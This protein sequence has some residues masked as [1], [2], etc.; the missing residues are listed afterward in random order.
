MT[1]FKEILESI[2]G[3][4]VLD[5]ATGA[6]RF[7]EILKDHLASYA[8]IIG[9]DNSE[10]AKDG[11]LRAFDDP[12]IRFLA[13]DAHTLDF[14]DASFDTVG[15]CFSLH[16]LPDPLPVLHEMKRVLQPGGHLIV[17][18]MY[19]DNQSETQMT[20]VLLHDWWGAID[21][22]LGICHNATY[23]RQ[24]IF[25]MLQSLR[26]GNLTVYDLVDLTDDPHEQET[27]EFIDNII[28]QYIRERIPGVP[29]ESTLK[30]QGEALRQRLREIGY[31][32]ASILVSVM[33][34]H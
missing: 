10:R 17:S 21:T 32:N 25:A 15:I 18:E 29:N 14:P 9:V 11:F 27:V 26:L 20:H 2:P 24:E 34:K 1:T 22:A 13:M 16:H 5:V 31:H 19:R 12:A 30:E 28:D 4:R 7:V 33:Q 8:E 6:G 23:R 3:G